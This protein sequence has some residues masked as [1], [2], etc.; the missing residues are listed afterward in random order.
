MRCPCKL[1]LSLRSAVLIKTLKTDIYKTASI[2]S[3]IPEHFRFRNYGMQVVY[4]YRSLSL[5]AV[6]F[7]IAWSDKLTT[8]YQ[9]KPVYMY[10]TLA[11]SL[12]INQTDI[13]ITQSTISD[14]KKDFFLK[15]KT[16]IS[17]SK[18]RTGLQFINSKTKTRLF[19][20][21]HCVRCARCSEKKHL[22]FRLWLR[23]FLVD[24]YI[25]IP[26]ETGINTLQ[27][28]NLMSWWRH[29]CV[30]LN[31]TKVSFIELKTNIGRLRC[32][33]EKHP[34]LFLGRFLYFLYQ[35]KYELILYRA[36]VTIYNYLPNCVSTL[37]NKKAHFDFLRRLW[38]TASSSAFD[39]TCESSQLSQNVV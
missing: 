35:R 5:F 15:T 14:V 29:N 13:E 28:T 21:Q 10:V 11:N 27:Y 3:P 30:T 4:W 7:E 1:P 6:F 24:F 8:S 31:I 36:V 16:L 18:P 26:L 20:P 17:I 39:R 37:P 34:L 12:F 23:H 25:F 9:T 32:V 33:Q 19:V 2:V 38:P 22:C